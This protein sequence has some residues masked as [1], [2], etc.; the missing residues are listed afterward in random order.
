M[1]SFFKREIAI[2]KNQD[3]GGSKYV[4]KHNGFFGRALVRQAVKKK[5]KCVFFK[6]QFSLS[7][8]PLPGMFF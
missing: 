1:Q 2:R 6:F 5:Y 8:H 7:N 3:L 4:L